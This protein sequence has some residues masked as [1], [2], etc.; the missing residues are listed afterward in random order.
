MPVASCGSSRD[1][2]YCVVYTAVSLVEHSCEEER[3]EV[4]VTPSW[5]ASS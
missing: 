1:A 2:S 3:D 5:D 4:A